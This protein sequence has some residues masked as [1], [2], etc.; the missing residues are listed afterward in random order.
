MGR[1]RVAEM[2]VVVG[3][4]LFERRPYAVRPTPTFA[5]LWPSNIQS[6]ALL[7]EVSALDQFSASI[8][9]S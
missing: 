5:T 4:P 1:G 3:R 7:E 6:R 2:I 8:T 9:R